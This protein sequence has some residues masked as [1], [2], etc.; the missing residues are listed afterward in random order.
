[1]STGGNKSV[2]IVIPAYNEAQRI[3]VTLERIERHFS[4]LARK[5]EL[6]VVDDGSTDGTASVVSAFQCIHPTPVR[7]LRNPKNAGKGMSVRRGVL[8]AKGDLILFSDADLST[9]IEEFSKLEERVLAGFDLAIGSRMLPGSDLIIRQPRYREWMG[10]ILIVL[11][12]LLGLADVEDTQCGFKLFTRPA[13]RRIFEVQVIDRFGFDVEILWLARKLGFRIAEV[14]VRW[15]NNSNTRVRPVIDSMRTLTEVLRIYRREIQ[16]W[17]PRSIPLCL[18]EEKTSLAERRVSAISRLRDRTMDIMEYKEWLRREETGDVEYE[19]S[20]PFTKTFFFARLRL[21]MSLA[22]N[23]LPLSPGIRILDAGCGDGYLLLRLR[24]RFATRLPM[25]Y[26]CDFSIARV[27]EARRRT[28][29]THLSVA[30]VKVLPFCSD[31]F[32]LVVCTDVLEHV[33]A[34]DRAVL[35]LART[36]KPGGLLLLAIPHEGW[37]RVCRLLLLRFPLRVPG[38]INILS[39]GWIQSILPQWKVVKVQAMP[40]SRLPWV[41]ALHATILLQKPA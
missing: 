38:H 29:E 25:S 11:V 24:E 37:W 3:G 8:E 2:S 33:V 26:G 19:K 36:V 1:M 12:R 40:F 6:I 21:F 39:P 41:L 7:L 31:R 28:K 27:M 34:P 13:G 9:P 30:N 14:P 20:D 22:E 15:I 10:R 5:F 18:S 32:D 35:E 16:R 17:D 4:G 23:H